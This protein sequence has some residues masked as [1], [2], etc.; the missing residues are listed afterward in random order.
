M[1]ERAGERRR[2]VLGQ[3]LSLTLSPFVPHGELRN[4]HLI[5]FMD[6]QPS[7]DEAALDRFAAKGAT[8]WADVPDAAKWVREARGD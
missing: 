4:V 3:P 7:Y 2:L 5:S 8:A 6:Y 1:E